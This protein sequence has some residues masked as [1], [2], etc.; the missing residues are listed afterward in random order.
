[1][2]SSFTTRTKDH[3]ETF[4][5]F[6]LTAAATTALANPVEYPGYATAI[7]TSPVATVDG[8]TSALFQSRIEQG[9]VWFKFSDNLWKFNTFA[10]LTLSRDNSGLNYN[11]VTSPAVGMKFTRTSSSTVTDVGVQVVRERFATDL[12]H[13]SEAKTRF[14]AFVSV[15]GAWDL[16]N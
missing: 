3:E 10:N 11:N 6:I 15:V 9:I 2:T 14:Q 1:M 5:A 13:F 12:Y 8:R 4:F 7:V 16:K